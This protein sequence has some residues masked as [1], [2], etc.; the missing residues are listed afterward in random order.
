M[1]IINTV[2][3]AVEIDGTEYT[4]DPSIGRFPVVYT[5]ENLERGVYT[6]IEYYSDEG[7]AEIN[8]EDGAEIA[9]RHEKLAGQF[10]PEQLAQYLGGDRLLECELVYL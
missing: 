5:Y 2:R 1:N 4:L 3:T 7:F 10:T 6:Y 9:R 8:A